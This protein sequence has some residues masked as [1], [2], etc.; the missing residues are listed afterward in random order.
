MRRPPILTFAFATI[1]LTCALLV[2]TGCAEQPRSALYGPGSGY[3]KPISA[4][5]VLMPVDEGQAKLEFD[6][7]QCRCGIFPRNVPTPVM[8]RWQPDQQRLAETS[9][10]SVKGENCPAV[11]Q[12]AFS[13]CM[14]S[15]GWEPTLCAGR[16]PTDALGFC[17]N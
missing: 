3:W 9:L 7:S 12:T 15:R 4:P 10:A 2:L 6:F 13:E 1:F 5:N 8:S 14:R 16:L 11:G 17:T